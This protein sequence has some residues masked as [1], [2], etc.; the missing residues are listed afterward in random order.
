MHPVFFK[1]LEQSSN[2]VL[3]N[4]LKISN[5]KEYPFSNSQTQVKSHTEWLSWSSGVLQC[6][7]QGFKR[8]AWISG[9]SVDE[10]TSI[11]IQVVGEFST[12]WLQDWN[13]H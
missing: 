11:L 6:R 3:M 1:I 12:M 5:L 8:A 10:F 13:P 2:T 4:Y 9:S 7:N